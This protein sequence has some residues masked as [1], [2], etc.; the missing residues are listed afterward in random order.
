MK[1]YGGL[2]L[3][4]TIGQAELLEA[5]LV[6]AETGTLYDKRVVE[7]IINEMHRSYEEQRE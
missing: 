4:L 2:K 7:S 1:W 3:E 5:L 6:K